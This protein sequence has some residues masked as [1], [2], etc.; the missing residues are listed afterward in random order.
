LRERVQPAGDAWG[1]ILLSMTAT[2]DQPSVASPTEAAL[3][4]QARRR[5]T[6]S[7]REGCPYLVATDGGWRGI[8]G[9]KDH[10][11][12]ATLPMA[13]PSVAKQRDVC[14]AEAHRL[15]ATYVAAREL[16][17]ASAAGTHPE[18]DTGFWPDTRS[19][20]VALEAARP[21][22]RALPGAPGRHG[23]QV[24]LV[25]LMVLAFLVLVIARTT[26]PSSGSASPDAGGG[27]VASVS[28][29]VPTRDPGPTAAASPDPSASVSPSTP[30]PAAS[31]TPA[32]G[33]SQTPAATAGPTP[34]AVPASAKR[35]RVRSGDTLSSIASRYGTTVKKL[36]AANGLK[37]NIIHAGQVL[38]I[39]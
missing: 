8:H 38:I 36:K 28:P 29:V 24:L 22:I 2:D 18:P 3:P 10:R 17:L 6:A 26:P 9:T 5:P 19:T 4:T 37:N 12:G 25:G 39:P 13:A 11:C 16:E 31:R 27:V 30:S 15:C 33:P 35:Y 1:G 23:G 21:R 20:L 7:V 14:L 32:P 34:T